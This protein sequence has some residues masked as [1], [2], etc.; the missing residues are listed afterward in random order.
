MSIHIA[1]NILTVKLESVI[2]D[3]RAKWTKC[4][5]DRMYTQACVFHQNMPTDVSDAMKGCLR[6]RLFKNKTI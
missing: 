1:Y 2:R 3:M 6:D 4:N 5:H